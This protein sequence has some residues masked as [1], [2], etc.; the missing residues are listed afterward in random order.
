MRKLG[1][2][3][4]RGGLHTSFDDSARALQQGPTLSISPSQ[5][6]GGEFDETMKYGYTRKVI[7]GTQRE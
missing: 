4:Q 3:A 6:A 2:Q 7:L 5:I 1:R